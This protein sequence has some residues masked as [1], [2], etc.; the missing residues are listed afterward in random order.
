MENRLFYNICNLFC[1]FF[2]LFNIAITPT[3]KAEESIAHFIT[4]EEIESEEISERIKL[5]FLLKHSLFAMR[6]FKDVFGAK[7]NE[8]QR[9]DF[10]NK[11]IFHEK[12][13]QRCFREAENMCTLI[14]DISLKDISVYLFGQALFLSLRQDFPSVMDWLYI[15]LVSYGIYQFQQWQ[16][17]QTLILESKSH[18]ELRDF[19]KDL[20]EKA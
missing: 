9:N 13:G 19:Y 5:I 15:S 3:C 6:N 18:F 8:N 14:P 4:S 12:E 17:M 2:I 10:Y 7:I 11:M 20:L 1:C 16:K